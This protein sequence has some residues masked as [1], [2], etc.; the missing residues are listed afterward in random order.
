MA[1]L[2]TENILLYKRK[3]SLRYIRVHLTNQAYSPSIDLR[4]KINGHFQLNN[5]KDKFNLQFGRKPQYLNLA[6]E[7]VS[8]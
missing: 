6:D 2:Y 3:S 1:I 5:I 7:I 4:E 8:S